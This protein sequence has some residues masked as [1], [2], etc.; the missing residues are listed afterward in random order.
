MPIFEKSRNKWMYT[1]ILEDELLDILKVVQDTF[2]NPLFQQG[3]V[4]IHTA[5]NAMTW[6]EENNAEVME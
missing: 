6:F 5:G 2:G 4:R 1:K 3:N